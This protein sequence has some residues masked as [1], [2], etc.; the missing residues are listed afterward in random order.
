MSE[1]SQVPLGEVRTALRSELTSRGHDVASDTL[2]IRGDLYILGENDLALAL[3]EFH[4]DAADA[5]E[6]MYRGSGSWVAGMPSRFAVLPE[7]ESENP[8]LE[9]LL[10]I[11]A[12]PLFYE[13]SDGA[14][15]F[16]ELDAVLRDRLGA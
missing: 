6:A 15:S 8:G 7:S 5:A 11:R 1:A 12:T 2:G 13:T 16:P 10:Q 14:V 4:T 9:M 3:F